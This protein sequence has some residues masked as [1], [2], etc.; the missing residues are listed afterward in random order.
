MIS[1]RRTCG[2]AYVVRLLDVEAVLPIEGTD[3]KT[4]AAAARAL[5]TTVHN[6]HG[7]IRGLLC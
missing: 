4:A 2:V 7:E 3:I 6:T 5:T 1:Y